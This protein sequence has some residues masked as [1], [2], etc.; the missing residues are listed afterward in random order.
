MDLYLN[1][2]QGNENHFFLSVDYLMQYKETYQI[3]D[4]GGRPFQVS[5]SDN[6][7][8][9]IV[10]ARYGYNNENIYTEFVTYHPKK[11]F[12][13]V[14]PRNQM[15]ESGRGY[16][17]QFDGNSILLYMGQRN[18]IFIGSTIFMFQSKCQ[19]DRFLS[20]VWNDD[21][22]YPYAIDQ[23]GNVYLFNHSVILEQSDE[24]M[25]WMQGNSDPTI[26]YIDR[27]YFTPDLVGYM[28]PKQ[29]MKIF[30]NIKEFYIGARPRTLRY[31]TEKDPGEEFE[32]FLKNLND[33]EVETHGISV[34]YHDETK[35]IIN[36]KEYVDL[37]KD[38]GEWMGFKK[39]HKIM[40]HHRVL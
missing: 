1:T 19:I 22:P 28:I 24:L 23:R 20:P 6:G 10:S 27:N 39:L 15:T 26:Y 29:P 7:K 34:V 4:N 33:N 17:E 18:Y 32:C 11:I 2:V 3:H 31:D 12:I 30:E 35:K 8:K 37:M 9:V 36:K 21:V 14:S 38:F 13:G 5:V 16:G 25:E 40:V